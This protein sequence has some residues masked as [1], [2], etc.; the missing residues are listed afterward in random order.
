MFDLPVTVSA[1]LEQSLNRYLELDTNAM[2][3][4]HELEGKV[5][6]IELTGINL[7]VFIIP[8]VRTVH[9]MSRYDGDVDTRLRGTPMALL[10]MG[11]TDEADK[12][13]LSGQVSIEGDIH[14]GQTFSHILHDIDIDWEEHLSH[15]TGDVIAHQVGSSIRR[16]LHWGQ[17]ASDTLLQDTAEFL[18]EES[19]LVSKPYEIEDF[20]RAVDTLRDDV[21]RLSLRIERLKKRQHHETEAGQ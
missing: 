15:L 8:G 2:Q 11:L 10:R 17:Q 12:Q 18:E 14:T 7:S 4:M 13:L 6:G 19:E 21:E 20:T 5:I 9:V 16:L 1:I 3:K